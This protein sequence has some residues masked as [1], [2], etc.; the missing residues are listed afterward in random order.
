MRM[1]NEQE[2]AFERPPPK[3]NAELFNPKAAAGNRRQQQQQQQQY[4]SG[5]AAPSPPEKAGRG[6]VDIEVLA[7]RVGG[8]LK[9]VQ[10]DGAEK[11]AALSPPPVAAAV[12]SGDS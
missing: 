3:A 8:G 9:I 5:G 7:G 2:N 10:G 12:V 4:D 6:V 1:M 11:I